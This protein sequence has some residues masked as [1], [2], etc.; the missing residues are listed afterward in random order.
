MC[1][2]A[3]TEQCTRESSQ[4]FEWLLKASQRVRRECVGTLHGSNR[5]REITVHEVNLQGK[6][7]STGKQLV[8]HVEIDVPMY[9]VQRCIDCRRRGIVVWKS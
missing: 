6:G 4:G 9:S 1:T 2:L 3:N 8:G 5:L 7:S